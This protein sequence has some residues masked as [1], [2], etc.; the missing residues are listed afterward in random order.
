[1][2]ASPGGQ[3][4]SELELLEYSIQIFKTNHHHLK[5]LL[6]RYADTEFAL[7]VWAERQQQDLLTESLFDFT[8]TWPR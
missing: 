8:T 2:D 6:K 1:M 4:L 5:S 7:K 3:L